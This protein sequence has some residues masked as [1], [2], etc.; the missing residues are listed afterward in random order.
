MGV[1]GIKSGGLRGR[2][3]SA[4][5]GFTLELTPKQLTKVL[6]KPDVLALT[7]G[8]MVGWGWIILS[9]SWITKAGVLGAISAFL[10]CACLCIFVGL[11][12]AELTAALPL[13]G[14][15][16]VFTYR[17]LGYPFAWVSAWTIIFAYV[18][19]AAWEGIAISTAISYILP[20]PQLGYLWTIAGYDVYLS[21]SLPGMVIVLVMVFFNL[22][23]MKHSVIFQIVTIFC[24]VMIGLSFLFG[25]VVLGDTNNVVPVWT[26]FNGW[27]AV[28]MMTPS[29]FIG[30]DVISAFAEEIRFPLKMIGKLV[31]TSILLVVL[32]YTLMIIAIALSAAP[33]IREQSNVAAADLISHAFSSPYAGK[34]L[35]LGGLFG[36]LT[37]WNGFV[38]AATRTIFA[39][40]RAKLLPPIFGKL[41]KKRQVPVVPFVLIGGISCLAPLL[42]MNALQ[43][44][45]NASSFATVLAYF[46]VSFSFLVL[47][48]K[49]PELVR[50]FKVPGGNLVGY[51]AVIVSLLFIFLFAPWLNAGIQMRE[52]WLL[53]GIWGIMGVLLMT[54]SLHLYG[55][56]GLSEREHL[57]Y[58]EKYARTFTDS[59]VQKTGE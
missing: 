40:G 32:W 21:W 46:F 19:V 7:F 39:M 25:G 51:A 57:I 45:V 12:F 56:I 28:L 16:M 18:G 47:R 10:I 31:I 20:I 58:T 35:I 48:K 14:G 3:Y 43:W 23:G 9:A 11:A 26:D 34:I 53:I 54:Y 5:G 27:L 59:G 42:G 50:P 1:A 4:G 52:E 29:M 30:F 22:R 13:A 37:T 36:I 55:R 38:L 2:P 41:Q 8:T 33:E 17:G 24:M 15:V 6:S 49:E 44:F